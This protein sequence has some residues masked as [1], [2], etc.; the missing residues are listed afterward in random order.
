MSSKRSLKSKLT[1]IYRELFNLYGEPGCPLHHDSPF[2]L[3]AATILSAQCT[4]L[5]VNLV[6]KDLFKKWPDAKSMSKAEPEDVEPYIK[7]AGLYHAKAVSL[8][9]SAR[10]IMVDFDGEVPVTMDELT[11]LPGVGRKTANV[12]LGNAFDIPGFPVDTHVQRLTMRLGVADIKDPVKIEKIVCANIA[13]KYWT[14]FS[15]LLIVHGRRVCSARKPLCEQCPLTTE[16]RYYREEY[17]A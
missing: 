14:N 3:L 7:T 15:H 17:T 4:D 16:C 9:G 5:R 10:K 2:Q 1:F 13:A 12:I 6:T 8:V 11:T